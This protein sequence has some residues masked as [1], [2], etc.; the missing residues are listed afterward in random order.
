MTCCSD[1]DHWEKTTKKCYMKIRIIDSAL[2][3][4]FGMFT[5]QP[6]KYRIMINCLI[7]L[8]SIGFAFAYSCILRHIWKYEDWY[9][10]ICPV[11]WS[12]ILELPLSLWYSDLLCNPFYLIKFILIDCVGNHRSSVLQIDWVIAFSSWGH[13][14]EN[15]FLPE[16]SFGLG[17]LSSPASVGLCVCMCV[18][19]NHELVRTITHRPFKLGSPNL[20]QRCKTP[21]FR[22]LLF[23]GMLD[24]DLQGQI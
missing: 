22:S 12:I 20:D 3:P 7:L 18:C 11:L 10:M 14:M 15:L 24:L 6:Y 13:G 23:L 9:N 1:K 5:Y 2:T 16:A 8:M 21:W 4:N 17:V 19:I